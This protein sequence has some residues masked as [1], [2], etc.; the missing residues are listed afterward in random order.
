MEKNSF[1]TS[2]RKGLLGRLRHLVPCKER[3]SQEWH[4]TLRITEG[5][6]APYSFLVTCQ[7]HLTGQGTAYAGNTRHNSS[8]SAA[9]SPEREMPDQAL[10]SRSCCQST[11]PAFFLSLRI[12]ADSQRTLSSS[13]S[14]KAAETYC[15]SATLQSALCYFIS[16]SQQAH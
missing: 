13:S 11:S 2:E 14:T 7:P 5:T 12:A 16:F 4:N 1:W 10:E 3:G 9:L 6:S 8:N 15:V